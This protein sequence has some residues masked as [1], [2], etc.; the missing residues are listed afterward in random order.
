MNPPILKDYLYI[1]T[2]QG[3]KDSLMYLTSAFLINDDELETLNSKE[4]GTFKRLVTQDLIKY[5]PPYS[6]WAVNE[7]RRASFMGS[8]NRDTFLTDETGTRRFLC[9]AIEIIDFAQAKKIDINNVYAQ[10]FHLYKSG[11]QYWFDAGESDEITQRNSGF[12]IKMPAEELI[13]K[14]FMA[15][16]D[17]NPSNY[18]TA[19]DIGLHIIQKEK[20]NRNIQ[21]SLRNVTVGKA[22]AKLKHKKKNVR[23]NGKPDKRYILRRIESNES[24]EANE[25]ISKP[26]KCGE[27]LD[28]DVDYEHYKSERKLKCL[29]CLQTFFY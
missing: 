20:E 29:K 26:C 24:G 6:R 7:I 2:I 27:E 16:D 10:A 19:T 22:L 3:D 11:F 25:I 5:R 12:E 23:I 8:V 28:F 14:Y 9:F 15:T 1:G 18:W 4:I 21:I 17:N 13:P